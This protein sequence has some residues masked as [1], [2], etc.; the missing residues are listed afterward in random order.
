MLDDS[1]EPAVL[2]DELQ[3]RLGSDTLDGLEVVAAEEYT[4]VNEL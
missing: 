2:A 3:R 1:T 4:E